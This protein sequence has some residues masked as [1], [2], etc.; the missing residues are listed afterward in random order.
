MDRISNGAVTAARSD[1]RR[2]KTRESALHPWR[3]RYG[4]NEDGRTVE[5]QALAARTIPSCGYQRTGEGRSGV[6]VISGVPSKST[7][8]LVR[9]GFSLWHSGHRMLKTWEFRW[10]A[11][12]PL[13]QT[14][15]LSTIAGTGMGALQCKHTT[16]RK[17]GRSVSMVIMKSSQRL[18]F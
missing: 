11:S 16:P 3:T 4:M 5:G 8:S 13:L 2:V 12:V 1:D 18:G 10:G 7:I 9:Y 6:I 17:V 15:L 14:C